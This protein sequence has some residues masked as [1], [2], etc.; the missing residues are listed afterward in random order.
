LA[1]SDNLNRSLIGLATRRVIEEMAVA[2]LSVWLQ[3][4][5]RELLFGVRDFVF[6][7]ICWLCGQ[8]METEPD[9][10]RSCQE[11]FRE[12]YRRACWRCGRSVGPFADTSGGC[13]RCAGEYYPFRS[14]RRLGRYEG[15]LREAILKI[16]HLNGEGLAVALGRLL[17]QML[18]QT[19]CPCDAVVPVPLH[20]LR[21][22]QRGYNQA[23]AIAEGIAQVLGKPVLPRLLRRQRYTPS[24]PN[25]PVTRREE[26][27]RGAFALGRGASH[28]PSAI[29]L[30]DDVMTTGSTLREAARVLRSAGVRQIHVAVLAR[31]EH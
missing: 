26:N 18:A 20:W 25:Q 19:D 31:A 9:F 29:L 13:D 1:V 15:V 8:V 16:K 11:R 23:Q 17:G 28:L 14:V 7:P 4:R 2:S 22:W 6:P 30:V 5:F 21:Y 27:L 24:Q 12:S 10:C 3:Q